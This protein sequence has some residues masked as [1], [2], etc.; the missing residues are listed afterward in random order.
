MTLR[1]KIT[2]DLKGAMKNKEANRLATL[3]LMI[4]VLNNEGIEKR[5][6]SGSEELTDEEVMTV[7]R[8]EVKKRE[9]SIGIYKT[10]GRGEL[11]AQEEGEL[12]IKCARRRYR[13]QW[14]RL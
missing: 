12:K 5:R 6:K 13:R 14:I 4:S 3:R 7:L 8:R 11:A 2:A 9:E 10:A 1:E